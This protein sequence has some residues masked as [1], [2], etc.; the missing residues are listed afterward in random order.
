LPAPQA[1]QRQLR[2]ERHALACVEYLGQLVS[3]LCASPALQT[4][5]TLR[6]PV[7]P[8][9]LPATH[10]QLS[11]CPTQLWLELHTTDWPTRDFLRPHLPLFEAQL[12]QRM[13]PCCAVQ[14]SLQ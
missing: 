4:Q 5:W 7:D 2:E 6:L 3:R 9:L 10:L 1:A 12:Q 8:E 14:V 11:Y 13:L